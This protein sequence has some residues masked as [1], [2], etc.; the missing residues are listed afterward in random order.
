MMDY[1]ST[2]YNTIFSEEYTIA[3]TMTNGSTIR[4]VKTPY[5]KKQD[6]PE[7][8]TGDSA[9]LDAFLGGFANA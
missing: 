4:I 6:E 2:D 5:F 9:A 1:D 7:L 3:Y 8:Q